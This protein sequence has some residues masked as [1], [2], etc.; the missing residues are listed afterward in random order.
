MKVSNIFNMAIDLPKLAFLQVIQP[1]RLAMRKVTEHP[2]TAQEMAY[3][4]N[5]SLKHEIRAG[6]TH[7]FIPLMFV[8]VGDRVFARRYS[9]NEPSWHSAF[10]AAPLGQIML[11]KTI[12]NIDASVPED[13]EKIVSDVDQA[14][15]DRLKKFGARFLLNGATEPRAQQST[16]ELTLSNA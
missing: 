13:L 14:Y 10:R 8:T 7:R 12:V 4:V 3:L 6:F 16:I 2:E 9:Y 5:T 1:L 11:D 15:A